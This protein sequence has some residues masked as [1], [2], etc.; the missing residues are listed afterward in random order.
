MSPMML[1]ESG[2]LAVPPPGATAGPCSRAGC[3]AGLR[4]CSK[5][6]PMQLAAHP[7]LSQ[8]RSS[9]PCK[10]ARLNPFPPRGSKQLGHLRKLQEAPHLPPAPAH[11][12]PE[13]AVEE[14]RV[15]AWCWVSRARAR[16]ARLL[17]AQ[18]WPGLQ[19]QGCSKR[20]RKQTFDTRRGGWKGGCGFP[21]ADRGDARTSQVA[22]P[23]GDGGSQAPRDAALQ[24]EKR[25]CSHTCV[26]GD[27]ELNA[28]LSPQEPGFEPK[29]P[30]NTTDHRLVF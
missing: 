4:G 2:C 30:V 17:R 29:S 23:G 7:G 5:P 8:G 3:A 28:A 15:L 10:A 1:G 11:A 25:G 21:R 19:L 27:R 18:V 16:I 6:S 12:R 14:T 9:H 20:G 24:E 22:A 13:T 26:L